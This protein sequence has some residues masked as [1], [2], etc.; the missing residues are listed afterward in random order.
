MWFENEGQANSSGIFAVALVVFM[1]VFGA[2]AK[3][4]STISKTKFSALAF[5]SNIFVAAFIGFIISLVC[6]EYD[7]S[8]NLAG[9]GAGIAGYS[10]HIFID[11]IAARFEKAAEDKVDNII[12][13]KSKEEEK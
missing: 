13:T 12:G 5:W 11:K 2:A 3:Y 10:G 6:A 9:V 8:R 4:M 7:V 1:S